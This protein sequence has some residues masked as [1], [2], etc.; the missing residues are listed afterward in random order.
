[1][2]TVVAPVQ[3]VVTRTSVAPPER[4]G[5]PQTLC[6]EKNGLPSTLCRGVTNPL[7]GKETLF[8]YFRR[9]GGV[10]VM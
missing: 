10:T 4:G 3:G 5:I 2:T 1:M 9:I 6:F 7:R 8:V